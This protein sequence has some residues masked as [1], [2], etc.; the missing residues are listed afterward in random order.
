MKYIGHMLAAIVVIGFLGAPVAIAQMAPTPTP[1]PPGAGRL[2]RPPLPP[3]EKSVDGPV[4]NVDSLAKT[5]KVG[6]LMGLFSTTLRVDDNTRIN[7]AG[8]KASLADIQEG[9][10]VKASYESR[11]DANVAKAIDVEPTK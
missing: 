5:V 1:V 4:K 3:Q 10:R 7:V 6:W 8:S 2:A 9:D 11:S